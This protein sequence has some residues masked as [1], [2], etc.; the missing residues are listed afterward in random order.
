MLNSEP[1]LLRK[2]VSRRLLARIRSI[3]EAV[4]WGPRGAPDADRLDWLVADA[5]DFLAHAGPRTRLVI[6]ISVAAVCWLAP[7]FI[8][9]F[10]LTRLALRE[11]MRALAALE[12]SQLSAP[13][14]ATK[15]FLSLLYYEHPDAQREVGFDGSCLVPGG[16][17]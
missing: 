12:Q 5:E 1:D 9:R 10:R 13:L 8:G 14:F 3:A 7:L 17:S 2:R 6:G 15:A 4:C 11:R 16:R